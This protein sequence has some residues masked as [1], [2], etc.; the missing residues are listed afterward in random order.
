MISTF[1]KLSFI[2]LIVFLFLIFL[3]ADQFGITLFTF[4]IRLNYI[5]AFILFALLLNK[6]LYKIN[7]RMNRLYSIYL[8][9]FYTLLSST[10]S[11]DPSRTLL[12]SALVFITLTLFF[13]TPY[14]L[15]DY[16]NNTKLIKYFINSGF[17][18]GTYAFFQVFLSIFNIHDPFAQQ[19]LSSGIVRG[20]ALS[21]EPSFY[22]LYMVPIL[23]LLISF[24]ILSLEKFYN[25][26]LK[27]VV[28]FLFFCSLSI[29]ASLIILPIIIVLFL[30]IFKFICGCH[31]NLIFPAFV[32]KKLLRFFFTGIFLILV[33]SIFYS[34]FLENHIFRIFYAANIFEHYSSLERLVHVYN[35]YYA[36]LESPVFGHGL[37]GVGQFIYNQYFLGFDY[38]IAP[39]R[40][41]TFE[42]GPKFFEPMNVSTEL[43]ASYGILGSLIYFYIYFIIVKDSILLMRSK[44]ISLFNVRLLYALL[45]SL[46]IL[47]I[48]QN[49]NQG[50]YRTYTWFFLGLFDAVRSNI[51]K[52]SSQ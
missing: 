28:L 7:I 45:I 42:D 2:K 32:L 33:I 40:P 1:S 16:L 31:S 51:S 52:L 19:I 25:Y 47:I 8:L 20:N 12:M 5:F 29:S 39:S 24:Y 13:L 48:W 23:A 3:H 35:S 21:H 36:F 50:L 22:L 41:L 14:L 44:Y 49:I 27:H 15:A 30:F 10:W 34:D 43:F 6:S 4:N 26:S 17:F 37:G 9:F 11:P 18:V 38:L 46:I